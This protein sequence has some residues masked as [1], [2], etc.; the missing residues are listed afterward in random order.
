[1]PKENQIPKSS[2]RRRYERYMAMIQTKLDEKSAIEIKV[3]GIPAHL[4]DF[5]LGGLY[6]RADKDFSLGE[7]VNLAIDLGKKG[8][9]SLLGT[10]VRTNP[11][12][13]N[14]CW[15]IAIDLAQFYG[16]KITRRT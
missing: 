15:G 9:I 5:A 6:V 3:D 10:V 2:E 4:Q 14:A 8:K 16:L 12:P 11:E 7:T 1:M 13:D